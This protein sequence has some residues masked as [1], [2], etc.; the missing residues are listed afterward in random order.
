MRM[1]LHAQEE[2]GI[3]STVITNEPP[4]DVLDVLEDLDGQFSDLLILADHSWFNCVKARLGI[5]RIGFT[6]FFK[7]R[8]IFLKQTI[9]KNDAIVIIIDSLD[10]EMREVLI[11][12]SKK[13]QDFLYGHVETIRQQQDQEF[14]GR[15]ALTGILL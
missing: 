7:F 13:P 4:V 5:S 14:Q 12:I 6:E 1:S 10:D 11:L 15:F 8:Q 3:A 2:C 9:E